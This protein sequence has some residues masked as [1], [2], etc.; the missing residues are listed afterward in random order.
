MDPQELHDHIKKIKKVYDKI[1]RFKIKYKNFIKNDFSWLNN[2]R[3]WN[4]WQKLYGMPELIFEHKQMM[5]SYKSFEKKL[6]GLE[7]HKRNIIEFN[8][9]FKQLEVCNS[10]KGNQGIFNKEF[11]MNNWEDCNDCQGH[12]YKLVSNKQ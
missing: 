1:D 6:E 9:L 4:G 3:R 7:R 11:R 10:C 5:V 8:N 12:G 2:P